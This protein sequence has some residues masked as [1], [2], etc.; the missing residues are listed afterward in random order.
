MAAVEQ[1]TGSL[2]AARAGYIDAL[3]AGGACASAS[4][5]VRAGLRALK[6]GTRLWSSGC[7][8]RSSRRRMRWWP[9]RLG[10]LGG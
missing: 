6:D 10:G 3:V 2:P 1:Q 8:T 9:I 4:E 7:L 5:V